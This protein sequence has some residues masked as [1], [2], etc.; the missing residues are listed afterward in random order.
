MNAGC[1]TNWMTKKKQHLQLPCPDTLYYICGWAININENI[2]DID[3]R[4]L[5]LYETLRSGL[6]H[7]Q[8]SCICLQ[9]TI[10]KLRVHF[11][12]HE[13]ALMAAPDL[14]YPDPVH[15]TF[16]KRPFSCTNTFL[17]WLWLC[18]WTQE[19]DNSSRPLSSLST[20]QRVSVVLPPFGETLHW[21]GSF[22][23]AFCTLSTDFF[24]NI[25]LETRPV[26]PI[27]VSVHDDSSIL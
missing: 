19:E 3:I 5:E 10:E 1:W 4:C 26:V 22:F 20:P 15:Q 8:P 25:L 6:F 13:A 11:A 27:V 14:V 12:S 2:T 23:S 17:S 7:Q 16:I 18:T 24:T 9:Q 21:K